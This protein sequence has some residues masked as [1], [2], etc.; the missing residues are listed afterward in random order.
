MGVVHAGG[1]VCHVCVAR[2]KEL[3]TRDLSEYVRESAPYQLRPGDAKR[4]EEL[5]GLG[6]E[7][8]AVKHYFGV[9]EQRWGRERLVVQRVSITADR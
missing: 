6:Q 8:Q 7:R 2:T 3:L 1:M 5:L 9:A 4:V